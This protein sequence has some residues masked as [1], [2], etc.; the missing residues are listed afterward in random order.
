MQEIS[1]DD[2]LA[3]NLPFSQAIRE[4]DTIY[5]SGQ[6]P[7]DPETG[8]LIDTDNI[9]RE[10]RQT[11][12][13]ISRILDAAGTDLNDVLKVNLYITDIDEF[14]QINAEYAA[15]FDEPYPTR[16]AV[17]V[18]NLAVDCGIEIDVVAAI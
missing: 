1:T 5:V 16:T 13:N 7:L 15:F 9:G 12:E 18:S 10:T 2:E 3:L 17:E 11:L 4:N 14:D 8:N 6:V